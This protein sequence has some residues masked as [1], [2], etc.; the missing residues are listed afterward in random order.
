MKN[1]TISLLAFLFVSTAF[2]QDFAGND[3]LKI[4]FEYKIEEGNNNWADEIILAGKITELQVNKGFPYVYL[5]L[6]EGNSIQF[7]TASN[8]EGEFEF[9]I[10]QGRIDT[11]RTYTLRV[12]NIGCKSIEIN[13]V[14]FSKAAYQFKMDFTVP[15]E[16]FLDC[17]GRVKMPDK[18]K[19]FKRTYYH[20]KYLL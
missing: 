13:D 6:W 14:D 8:S 1:T 5:T 17:G 12:G 16:E 11:S 7:E 9:L 4:R 2:S 3:L 15:W 19:F 20:I 18:E 10:E